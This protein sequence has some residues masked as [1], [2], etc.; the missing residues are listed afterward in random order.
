MSKHHFP[1][2]FCRGR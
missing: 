2:L 1:N